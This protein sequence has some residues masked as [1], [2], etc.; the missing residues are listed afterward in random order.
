MRKERESVILMIESIVKEVF[1]AKFENFRQSGPPTIPIGIKQYGS[2]ASSLAVDS[3]DVDLAVTG[4]KLNG[5][6]EFHIGEMRKLHGYLQSKQSEGWIKKLEIIDTASVP[7][8]KLQVDL[9]VV[10]EI[11]R[12]RAALQAKQE[13]DVNFEPE[14]FV[15]LDE[16]MAI[17]HIDITF[18]DYN[19]SILNTRNL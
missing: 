8:I 6:I 10:Q 17:L 19:T 7:L 14:P 1:E 4:L 13:N 2:Q 9:Q 3:S 18:D 12:N 15:Q 5:D 16:S 11:T